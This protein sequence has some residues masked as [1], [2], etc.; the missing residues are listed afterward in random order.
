MRTIFTPDAPAPIGPYSQAVFAGKTLYI[1][2][3]TPIDPVTGDV[4]EGVAAQTEL[5]MKNI[6]AILAA[7]G[8]N[9]SHV[10]KTTCFLT[11]MDHFAAFNE[12]YA[13]RFPSPAPARST[14]AVRGLP[15][16]VLVEV[17]TIALAE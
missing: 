4:P 9:F 2:G 5:V 16:N 11:T 10:V 1:S 13:K 17:E 14:V 12:V 7:A 6:A 15:K 8:L 3:Q